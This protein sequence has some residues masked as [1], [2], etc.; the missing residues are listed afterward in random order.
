MGALITCLAI[1]TVLDMAARIAERLTRTA[2]RIAREKRKR[3]HIGK[4]PRK[5]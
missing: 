5:R 1:L 4:K 3:K 2:I